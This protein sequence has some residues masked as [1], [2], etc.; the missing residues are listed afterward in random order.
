MTDTTSPIVV[1]RA[2]EC[3][4]AAV[5]RIQQ[6]CPEAGQWPVGDYSAFEILLALVEGAPAGFCAWRQAAPDEAEILNLGVDPR[7]R[8]RGVAMALLDALCGVAQGEV[9]LE[10]AETNHPAQALY[11]R[12]GWLAAGMRPGY[13][14]NGTINA[15]VMKKGSC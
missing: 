3:D 15:V 13:Y 10:V 14:Q 8:R 9:F 7:F 5:A 11:A 12:A 6:A 1:R 4:F 2:S